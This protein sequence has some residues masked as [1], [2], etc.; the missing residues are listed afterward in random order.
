MK[1][2]VGRRQLLV[3]LL[4]LLQ[5]IFDDISSVI[6]SVTLRPHQYIIALLSFLL[7]LFFIPLLFFLLFL[8]FGPFFHFFVGEGLSLQVFHGR[9]EARIPRNSGDHFIFFYL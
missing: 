3:A 9:A 8:L 7:L 6:F 4:V 5:Q 2:L 1:V